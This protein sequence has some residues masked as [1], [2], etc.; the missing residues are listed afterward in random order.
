MAWQT[1]MLT[2]Y[3]AVSIPGCLRESQ[4]GQPRRPPGLAV[5]GEGEVGGGT[6]GG[7]WGGRPRANRAGYESAERAVSRPSTGSGTRLVTSPPYL[8][9][10]LTRLDDRNAQSGLVEM[11]SVSTPAWL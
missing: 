2:G 8:A 7:F 9:N 4:P 11:N 3:R 10:S 1:E 5:K 6:R